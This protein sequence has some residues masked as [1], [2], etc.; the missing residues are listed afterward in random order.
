MLR[1]FESAQLLVARA[2]KHFGEFERLSKAFINKKPYRRICDRQSPAG[3]TLLKVKLVEDLPSALP[4]IAFDIVNCLRSALD[5]AAFDV[6][7]VVGGNPNP[8]STKFPFGETLADATADLPRH[9]SQIPE[10]IRPCLLGFEPYKGGKHSLWEINELRNRKIHRIL[11]G[12]IAAST[13][14]GFG[15][16]HIDYM[17]FDL[18]SKWDED[19]GELTYMRLRPGANADVALQVAVKVTF[20]EGFSRAKMRS[21]SSAALRK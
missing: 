9:H 1:P 13:G 4:A 20:G 12:T 21:R 6:A 16:G 5:H 17:N 7:V 8:K 15:N 10:S 14:V 11:V 19:K 2:G 18:M 3:D